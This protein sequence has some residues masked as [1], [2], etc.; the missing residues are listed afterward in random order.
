MS[1]MYALQALYKLC[2]SLAQTLDK[3]Y[4]NSKSFEQA[5]I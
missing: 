4:K 3:L 5:V 1:R 2:I